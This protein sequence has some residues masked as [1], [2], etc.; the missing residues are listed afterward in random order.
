MSR[1][2]NRACARANDCD[3]DWALRPATRVLQA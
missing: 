2:F 3:C 1:A